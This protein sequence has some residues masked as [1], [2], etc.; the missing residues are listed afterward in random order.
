MKF[1]EMNMSQNVLQTT[2]IN[3]SQVLYKK[4]L[5]NMN[6][7]MNESKNSTYCRLFEHVDHC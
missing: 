7:W 3:Q 5:K 1:L 4:G 2:D 6:E